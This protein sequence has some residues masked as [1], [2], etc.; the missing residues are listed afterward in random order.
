V[1][2]V[3]TGAEQLDRVRVE[4]AVR[5]AV[6]QPN[7]LSVGDRAS[8]HRVVLVAKLWLE[9]PPV[10][11]VVAFEARDLLLPRPSG[12]LRSVRVQPAKG[13]RWRWMWVSGQS[14]RVE[15]KMTK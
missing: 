1:L 10:V 7:D 11:V 2:T 9:L 3:V 6:L 5:V 4:V 8:V 14:L 15:R 12:V 13:P